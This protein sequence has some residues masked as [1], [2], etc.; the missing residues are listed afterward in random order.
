MKAAT[1]YGIYGEEMA[2]ITTKSKV[3]VNINSFTRF[4]NTLVQGMTLK[5]ILNGTRERQTIGKKLAMQRCMRKSV[6]KI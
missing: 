1:G 4:R 5:T 3:K 6:L 2:E